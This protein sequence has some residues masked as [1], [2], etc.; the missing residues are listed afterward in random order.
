MQNACAISMLAKSPSEAYRWWNTSINPSNNSDA[1]PKCILPK[2]ASLIW[3]KLFPILLF[4][5]QDTLPLNQYWGQIVKI[6][7]PLCK[8][9]DIPDPISSFPDFVVLLY[10]LRQYISPQNVN[11]CIQLMIIYNNSNFE[12]FF[13][14][15][16][17]LYVFE[18]ILLFRSVLEVCD[19][20]NPIWSQF[21]SH[22]SIADAFFDLH[23]SFLQPISAPN[24]SNKWTHHLILG[25]ILYRQI[26]LTLRSNQNSISKSNKFSD[27]LLRLI[28]S[29]P[30]FVRMTAARWL[31][32]LMKLTLKKNEKNVLKERIT[33]YL[34]ILTNSN[35][36]FIYSV[37]FI[38][39]HLISL[40]R[41]TK[42]INSIMVNSLSNIDLIL[43]F[44]EKVGPMIPITRLAKGS[45]TSK[46]WHRAAFSAM[47]EIITKYGENNE[48]K[49]WLMVYIR[50]VLIFVSLS[51]I[52]QKYKARA[53]LII[54]SISR[55]ASVRV[56]WIKQFILNVA[57][58][59][60]VTK[61]IPYYF[62]AFF[63]P[64][65]PNAQ[66][67]TI[68]FNM[69]HASND[70][71]TLSEFD[72]FTRCQALLNLKTFPFDGKKSTFIPPPQIESNRNNAKNINT[73]GAS[74][75]IV[76]GSINPML[77]LLPGQ[78]SRLMMQQRM[79]SNLQVKSQRQQSPMK[80]TKKKQSRKSS[81]KKSTPPIK[82]PHP[83]LIKH[84]QQA[85]Q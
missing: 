3:K 66:S 37:N 17:P 82:K 57:F 81:R 52:S 22:H 24:N 5:G 1:P 47:I 69:S 28:S 8:S 83:I 45:V 74:V 10:K 16:M 39:N 71:A 64:S 42:L 48:L 7:S 46:I 4:L 34:S 59:L 38:K 53:L 58:T 80:S 70:E 73:T 15:N 12:V 43:S 32:S 84:S 27:A 61:S 30:S 62:S 54:E 36:I 21:T 13:L 41:P 56:K 50:R 60:T 35:D 51:H 76:N 49:D 77:P 68:S 9:K 18:P 78:R 11:Q 75:N 31:L 29:S 26:S 55:L 6:V 72:A 19:K 23:L 63:F 33:Q 67:I 65:C 79:Q 40:I 44:T 85:K 2:E 14:Y 20:N 25:E